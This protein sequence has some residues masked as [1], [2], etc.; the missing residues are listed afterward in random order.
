MANT[1]SAR[2]REIGKEKQKQMTRAEKSGRGRGLGNHQINARSPIN[3]S[4]KSQVGCKHV[5]E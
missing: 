2:G 3:I 4:F 5:H 1:I